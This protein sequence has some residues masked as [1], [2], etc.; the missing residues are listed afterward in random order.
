MYSYN[1]WGIIETGDFCVLCIKFATT[2]SASLQVLTFVYFLFVFNILKITLV[3]V[4]S[5]T[6]CK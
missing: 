4:K 2:D 3:Y 6:T 5:N 1:S